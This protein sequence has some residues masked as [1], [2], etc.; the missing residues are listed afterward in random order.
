MILYSADATSQNQV[1]L[2]NTGL[3]ASSLIETISA[4]GIKLKCHLQKWW[5]SSKVDGLIYLRILFI[6]HVW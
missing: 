6:D 1:I 5:W 2:K 4:K 3:S